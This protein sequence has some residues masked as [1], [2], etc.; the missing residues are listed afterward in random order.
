VHDP[1]KVEDVDTD[2][3]DHAYDALRY[4]LMSRGHTFLK[5]RR[6]SVVLLRR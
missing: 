5:G 6:G 2:G 3:D 4:G 1:I